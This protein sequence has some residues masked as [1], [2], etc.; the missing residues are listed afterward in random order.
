MKM[1][2]DNNDSKNLSDSKSNSRLEGRSGFI[3]DYEEDKS[4]SSRS[5]KANETEE[6]VHFDRMDS[7]SNSPTDPFSQGNKNQL[8][9][10]VGCS[11]LRSVRLLNYK[12]RY[13]AKRA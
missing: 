10:Y 5:P 11:F 6:G 7:E 2:N 9:L 4:D 13:I 8:P 12:Q 1:E 3:E